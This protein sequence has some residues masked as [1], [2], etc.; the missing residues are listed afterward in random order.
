VSHGADAAGLCS[1]L[2]QIICP[3][4]QLLVPQGNEGLAVGT[5][6]VAGLAVEPG[7]LRHWLT[8]R[9]TLGGC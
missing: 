2:G 3:D 5:G 7:E 6:K 9:W 1:H 4:A 8:G